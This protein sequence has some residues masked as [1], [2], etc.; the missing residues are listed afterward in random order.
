MMFGSMLGLREPGA[1]GGGATAGSAASGG[2]GAAPSAPAPSGGPRPG[3][4][5]FFCYYASLVHQQNMLQDLVRTG[6]YHSAI[7]QNE[8]DFRGKV[9]V[10][11]GTGSGVLA[12]FAAR[13]GARRVYALEASGA[14][15]HARRLLEANGL[16]D[17]ITVLQSRVEDVVLPERAD[18]I[19]SEPMG[20]MLIHERMLESF[21]VARQRF[22][23]P[24][25][26]KMFPSRG[27][28]RV[29][30]FSDAALHAEQ[31]AK[32]AFW[33][34]TDF[35]GMDLTPLLE[36]AADDH[37]AQPVVGFV[38]AAS[39][40]SDAVASHRIDFAADDPASLQRVV[41]PF[42]LTASR[43]ALCH[44]IAAWFDVEF[45]GSTTHVTL[46]TGPKCPG[47]HWCAR[48]RRAAR[49]PP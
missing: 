30:L 7:L 39:L 37:F 42:A 34:A 13:A 8:A 21:I 23:K 25:G 1:D 36:A 27:D 44:G 19:I 48:R 17:R 6:A 3:D 38:D 43:A 49:T 5:P 2:A 33:G 31:V 12:F 28:V 18:V 14:A 22:L 20:F 46:S 16:G 15:V 26:G 9:V 29:T 32:L 4:N 47:T 35:F 41:V 10:D 24:E 45:L 11:V 40:L